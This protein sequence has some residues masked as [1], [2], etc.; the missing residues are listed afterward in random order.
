MEKN[1]T[2]TTTNEEIKVKK[3]A[4]VNLISQVILRA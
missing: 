4:R 1:T 2:T 3:A